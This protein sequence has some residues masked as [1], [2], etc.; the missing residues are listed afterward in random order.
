MKRTDLAIVLI[1]MIFVSFCHGVTD[2]EIRAVLHRSTMAFDNPAA[3][4]SELRYAFS[5][6][7]GDTN[8]MTRLMCDVVRERG[9]D[10]GAQGMIQ[11]IGRHGNASAL[12]FLYS[13]VTNAALGDVAVI[14]IFKIEGVT[15][16][17]VDKLN[18]F[19]NAAQSNSWSCAGCCA[20]LIESESFTASTLANRKYLLDCIQDYALRTNRYVITLDRALKRVD[21]G[22]EHS[23]RRLSILQSSLNR[24][25]GNYQRNY[26]TN[27]INELIAYPEANLND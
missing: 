17:S 21:S 27:A 4:E 14:S 3:N 5:L 13:C 24:G 18:A 15:T 22:Y 16:N 26:V 10:R 20:D 8:R 6:C 2:E 7:P 9:I 19:L 11:R 12:P 1:Q 23:R 25:I